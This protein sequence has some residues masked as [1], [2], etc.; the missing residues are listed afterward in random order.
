[1]VWWPLS[2]GSGRNLEYN[3]LVVS[4]GGVM[5]NL[6]RKSKNRGMAMGLA[7][8]AVMVIGVMVAMFLQKSKTDRQQ[9]EMD[10]GRKIL[11]SQG[12]AIYDF[13]MTATIDSLKEYTAK[14]AGF[15]G[16]STPVTLNVR[17]S[18]GVMSTIQTTC[19]GSSSNLEIHQG[20][21]AK[22]EDL[23]VDPQSRTRYKCFRGCQDFDEFPKI[24]MMT[25]ERRD[26]KNKDFYVAVSGRFEVV[27]GSVSEFSVGAFAIDPTKNV[28]IVNGVHGDL[29]MFFKTE[30]DG[31]DGD[32]DSLQN[33][34]NGGTSL[35][36]ILQPRTVYFIPPQ[37]QSLTLDSISTNV[38]P[39]NLC[40][41]QFHSHQW[42]DN[43]AYSL[44]DLGT[45]TVNKGAIITSSFFDEYQAQL[46]SKY[47]QG[48]NSNYWPAF[49]NFVSTQ[50]PFQMRFS[51]TM[52]PGLW[53]SF[54]A[55]A[56]SGGGIGSP[57][58]PGLGGNDGGVSG[59]IQTL[60]TGQ[61]ESFYAEGG[62]SPVVDHATLYLAC[63]S[64]TDCTARLVETFKSPVNGQ[65]SWDVYNGTVT[66]E[67]ALY[68]QAPIVRVRKEPSASGDYALIG[69]NNLYLFAPNTIELTTSIKRHPGLGGVIS[70]D[71]SRQGHLGLISMS[72]NIRL[73]RDFVAL[74]GQTLGQIYDSGSNPSSLTVQIDAAMV[75]AASDKAPFEI[76]GG[77]LTVPA[78]GTQKSIGNVATSGP[79]WGASQTILRN[80]NDQ[81]DQVLTGFK[82]VSTEY[83]S[84]W[85]NDPQL[86]IGVS[87]LPMARDIGRT[88]EFIDYGSA[89]QAARSDLGL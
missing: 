51:S 47:S 4:I 24:M 42:G 14:C 32:G 25:I 26:E 37:G 49:N 55:G 15:A 31:T 59:L 41:G 68:T 27:Q 53:V 21:W 19:A 62:I 44:T 45:V 70:D 33:P 71:P 43:W 61:N 22:I 7:L 52:S 60:D 58:G 23:V 29:A 89:L 63:S 8:I 82:N 79:V 57:D 35:N 13:L 40:I 56:K 9:V 5:K 78:D 72:N 46:V 64:P 73:G 66:P 65:S 18:D 54:L 6:N 50:S 81:L 11:L 88:F 77:L 86:S 36:P 16:T 1:M 20:L 75:S 69:Q 87:S 30:D 85:R 48:M 34:C 39:S 80:M 67:L 2:A 84:S 3:F 38:D 74:D 17:N 83:P 10:A 12:N 76:T 28:K